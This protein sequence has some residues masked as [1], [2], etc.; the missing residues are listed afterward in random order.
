MATDANRFPCQFLY[1]SIG[2]LLGMLESP[3]L[4]V[5]MAV[6]ESLALILESG[7]E[8]DENFLDEHLPRLIDATKLLATDSNKFRAKRDRKTQK[9][10]FRD[11]LRYL[12]VRFDLLR[13]W[14][15]IIL[16]KTYSMRMKLSHLFRLRA[17]N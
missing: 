6:G 10:T 2:N 13:V 17:S 7:R 1:R 3:H 5:R 11:V 12:E 15:I 16:L 4:D 14:F 9:A 8:H